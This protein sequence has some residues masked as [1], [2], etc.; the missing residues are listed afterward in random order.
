M[1]TAICFGILMGLQVIGRMAMKKY[2]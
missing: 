1:E 2:F